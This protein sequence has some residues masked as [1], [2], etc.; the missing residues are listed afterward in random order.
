L[1]SRKAGREAVVFPFGRD[2]TDPQWAG[3]DKTPD[4][5]PKLK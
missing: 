2:R 5:L 4:R 1:A 3:N